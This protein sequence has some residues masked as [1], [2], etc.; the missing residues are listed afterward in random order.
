MLRS[1]KYGLCGAVLAG[2]AAGT[3]SWV[4]IDKSVTLVVDG[5]RHDVRT[6][7]S[8][9]AGA[10]ADAGL[11]VG[12]RDLVAPGPHATLADGDRI[13]LQ[14]AR[15]L[16]L[17]VDG[18]RREVWTTAPTV[19]AAMA[20]LG[21]SADGLTSVSRSRRLPLQPTDIT[22]DLS[23]AAGRAGQVTPGDGQFLLAARPDGLAP[24]QDAVVYVDGRAAGLTTVTTMPMPAPPPRTAPVARA[25]EARALA[26]APATNSPAPPPPPPASTA[27]PVAPGAIATPAQA[28]DI[29]RAQLA[30]HG[31]GQDQFG[32]LAQ[33]WGHES[34]WRVQAGNP[35]TGAYGIPQALPGSKMGSVGPNWRTDAATQ[36]R[37]G[38]GYVAGRYGTP[39][40]AWGVFQ[41]KGW[42]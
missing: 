13:V 11:Q 17:D 10:L 21:W 2:L 20:E 9:V 5:Q 33:L 18:V 23:S 40:A 37:W 32:C 42:Y 28:Q 27:P 16:R 29:A 1:V 19:A 3:L 31:W 24:T 30:E 38:L 14:R 12:P 39:C 6:T 22:V 35:V 15:L 34:G 7:A 8:D 36:I 26:P 4:S 25:P 41:A